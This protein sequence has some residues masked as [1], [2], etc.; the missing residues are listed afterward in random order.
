MNEYRHYSDA[1]VTLDID[2]TYEQ[3]IEHKPRGFWL[4]VLG[5]DDW[6]SWCR[7]EEYGLDR[8]SVEH[9]VTLAS[10]AVIL[11]IT[12][13]DEIDAFHS[14]YGADP[15]WRIPS[16]RFR[17][18]DWGLVSESYD[19]IVIAPYVWPRR[20]N[21]PSW[22]YGWDCASGCIWNLDAIDAVRVLET[23]GTERMSSLPTEES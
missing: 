9:E 5:E 3:E 1:V 14:R 11:A 10:D 19:G 2:R 8:L 21:G 23:V 20:L 4:S 15:G 7:G 13:A 22:Y 17:S 12:S 16:D 6:P 18:I